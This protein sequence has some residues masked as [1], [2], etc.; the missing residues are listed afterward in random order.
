MCFLVVK[1]FE[2]CLSSWTKSMAGGV[3]Y[4]F[5]TQCGE[6]KLGTSFVRPCQSTWRSGFMFDGSK[7]LHHQGW[8]LSHYFTG[9]YISQLVQEISAINSKFRNGKWV[10]HVGQCG[11]IFPERFCWEMMK[12][13]LSH[14]QSF[15]HRRFKARLVRRKW[16][17][18]CKWDNYNFTWNMLSRWFKVPFSSPSWRTRF[19]PWKGHLTIP[20]RSLWITRLGILSIHPVAVQNESQ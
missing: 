7:I 3:S 15:S 1:N 2:D 6:T 10:T 19:T 8:W 17:E 16:W 12:I 4:S 14:N 9:F 11:V 13:K 5:A 18:C 20:K